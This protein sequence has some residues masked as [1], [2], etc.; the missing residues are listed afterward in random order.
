MDKERTFPKAAGI[1]TITKATCRPLKIFM[2][3][4]Y[5]VSFS[6][7]LHEE[8]PPVSETSN[9]DSTMFIRDRVFSVQ[10]VR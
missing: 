3:P 6:V 4:G 2:I 8:C 5:T 1:S 10:I 7:C 9:V